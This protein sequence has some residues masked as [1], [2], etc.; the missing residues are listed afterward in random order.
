MDEVTFSNIV[1]SSVC[2]TPLSVCSIVFNISLG[3]IIERNFTVTVQAVNGLGTS[4][5]NTFSG[6][7]SGRSA[8][9]WLPQIQFI[10]NFSC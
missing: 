6:I 8:I 10:I 9:R 4:N 1:N 3:E 2:V 7:L 5:I